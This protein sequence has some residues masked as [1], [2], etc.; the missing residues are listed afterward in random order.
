MILLISCCSFA[1]P[2]IEKLVKYLMEEHDPPALIKVEQARING[3]E[4]EEETRYE[5]ADK[6]LAEIVGCC[7]CMLSAAQ[8]RTLYTWRYVKGLEL[9]PQTGE[10]NWY[11]LVFGRRTAFDLFDKLN[12]A[13]LSQ[14][15]TTDASAIEHAKKV[16]GTFDKSIAKLHEK[17]MDPKY[18]AT[19][20]TYPSIVKG[21]VELTYPPFCRKNT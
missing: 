5:I 17:I 15:E 4:E 14:A 9:G 3:G 16:I 20:N 8:E 7:E 11:D 6:S 12:K 10:L 19:R 1:E 18:S 13:R 21:L 2:E